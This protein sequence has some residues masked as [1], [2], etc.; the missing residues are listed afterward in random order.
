MSMATV[1][2]LLG[3]NQTTKTIS[4][5]GLE[6][7]VSLILGLAVLAVCARITV[8]LGFT[9]VPITGQT[10]GVALIALLW[11]RTRGVSIVAT[12]LALGFVGVPVLATAG[13]LGATSGYLI[14]MF[15]AAVA[16]GTLADLGWTKSWKLTWLAAFIGSVITFTCGLIVLSSFVPGDA[17]LSAG[18]WPFIPGDIVKTLTVATLVSGVAKRAMKSEK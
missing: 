11:G 17:L 13:A 8:P 6:N 2:V 12:Y 18:L 10:F 16:M 5:R 4:H 3:K 7:V 15:F 1:P 9:P 14:G